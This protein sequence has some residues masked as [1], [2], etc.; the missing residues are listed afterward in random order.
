M[1]CLVTGGAG[2]IGSHLV[3]RLIADGHS[4]TVIDNE[5]SDAP[6]YYWNEAARNYRHNINDY[7]M[8][9][10]LFENQDVV[11]HLAALTKIPVCIEDPLR[12]LEDNTQGTASVLEYARVCRV[13][14]VVVSSTCAVYGNA[15]SPQSE[16][17]ATDCLNPYSLTK[18]MSEQLCRLYHRLYGVE[19]VCL[20]YF[21]VYGDRQPKSGAYAPVIGVFTDQRDSGLPLT[22]VGD[23]EQ[24]R[25]F[26]HVK[27][28]VDANILAS[29]SNTADIVGGIYN[30]GS[31]KNYSVNEIARMISPQTKTVPPR[32]G[33][34]KDV[35]ADV[36]RATEHLGWT[37]KVRLE[38]W[39]SEHK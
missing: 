22:I 28:V 7:V 34:C 13:K 5:S 3:E 25:D 32:V 23:G 12:T 8:V 9:R 17:T 24:R 4:V 11:F 26:V 38:D 19:S 29:V 1:N 21:N 39:L 2:F 18:L 15:P 30:I 16:T 10:R 33:E 6:C 36:T 27:D 20:R 35:L 14:R 31:G 37:P